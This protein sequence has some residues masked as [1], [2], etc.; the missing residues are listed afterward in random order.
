MRI[1]IQRASGKRGQGFTLVELLV[2]IAIIGILIALLLPAVQAAR[3]SQCTN[4]LKQMALAVHNYH[5]IYKAF[6]YAYMSQQ[7]RDWGYGAF[8]LPFIEQTA[9]YDEL[10]PNAGQSMPSVSTQPRLAQPIPAYACPSC[11]GGATNSNYESYAKLSYPPNESVAPHPLAGHNNRPVLMASITDGL[12]NTIMIGER[13]LG[14]TPF[15]ALGANWPGRGS[16]SSNSSVVGRGAW[17]PNT[18]HAGG[19]DG[20]CTRHAW[21][22]RHPGGINAALCDGSVRF[23]G[24]NIDSTTSYADCTA[25]EQHTVMPN[26]VFQNLYR[27]NDGNSIGEF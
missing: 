12:S 3:R 15:R 21:S 18:P 11:A 10:E 22:S 17:P 14:D 27:R 16:G 13:A 24:E 1:Q 19:S 23:L 4:N 7:T 20:A 8:L 26:R 2:V 9:L 5:D 25:T 6:P